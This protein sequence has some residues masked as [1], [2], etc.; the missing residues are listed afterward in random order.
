[1][2]LVHKYRLM[3]LAQKCNPNLSF[4]NRK[5]NQ[6]EEKLIQV[7]NGLVNIHFGV[8]KTATTYIQENLEL[9]IDQKF[10][11]TQLDEFRKSLKELGYPGY[12]RSLDWS[13]KI[14]ISD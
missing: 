7:N 14:V 8:H 3:R 5:I 10:H 13:K 11:Y 9:I 12:L 1:M 4:I 6:Y 2:F